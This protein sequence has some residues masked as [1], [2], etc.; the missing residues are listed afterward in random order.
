MIE[1]EQLNEILS[2][3]LAINAQNFTE[4]TPLLGHI[5]ELDSMGITLLVMR[6]ESEFKI[7]LL[8]DDME[9]SKFAT[10]GSFLDFVHQCA[11]HVQ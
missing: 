2:Q 11:N 8:N 5:P 9:A 4:Q 6:V 10:V 1:L 7:Q 3:S